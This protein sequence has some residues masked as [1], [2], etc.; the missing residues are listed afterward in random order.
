[1]FRAPFHSHCRA[2]SAMTITQIGYHKWPGLSSEAREVL[3]E[4]LFS[5]IFATYAQVVVPLYPFIGR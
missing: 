4:L 3:G 5:R 2:L 1:M